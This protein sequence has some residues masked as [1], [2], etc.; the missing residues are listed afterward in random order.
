MSR[1]LIQI[2]ESTLF[3]LRK[4]IVDLSD[5]L[6]EEGPDWSEDGLDSLR[7]RVANAVPKGDLPDWLHHYRDQPI[8]RSV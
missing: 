8:V 5:G 1:S 4:L 2:P 6:T 3:A 7:R